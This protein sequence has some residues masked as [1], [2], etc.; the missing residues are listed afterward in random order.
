MI[1]RLTNRPWERWEERPVAFCPS[2]LGLDF[3]PGRAVRGPT[4][5]ALLGACTHLKGIPGHGAAPLGD[6]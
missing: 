2:S 4:P 3:G 1:G 5:P 6:A